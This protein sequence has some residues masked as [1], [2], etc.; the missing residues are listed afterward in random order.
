[1][2]AALI[3]LAAGACTGG[4]AAEV[5]TL[6]CLLDPA[7]E[8]IMVAAHRGFHRDQPENSLA[9]IREAA[10]IGV[11]FVEVDVRSTGDGVLVLMHDSSVDRTTDGTGEIA[12][13]S[14]E[15]LSGLRLE[16]GL[17]SDPGSSRVAR[18]DEAL[19]LAKESGLM[20]YVDLKTGDLDALVADIRVREGEEVA[21][22]RDGLGTLVPLNQLA[23]DLL[24]MPPI[25]SQAELDAALEALPGL[26]IVEIAS[27][28]PD[29]A[30]SEAVHAAGLKVQ[31]DVMVGGDLL[32][33]VGDYSGWKGFVDAGVDLMQTDLPDLLLAA[34]AEQEQGGGFPV[35]GPPLE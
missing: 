12:A 16:G 29:V 30:L 19:A 18:F 26:R 7:C 28:L 25:A 35:S 32:A 34:L 3:V 15:E 21:L 10:R 9:A 8:R 2:L 4:G 14:W 17:A 31:Q 22:I 5:G 11:D 13:L 24:L 20:L 6:D 27:V 33:A 23:A 1:M